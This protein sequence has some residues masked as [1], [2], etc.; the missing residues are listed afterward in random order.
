[1]ATQSKGSKSSSARPKA[2]A[3]AKRATKAPASERRQVRA[4]A[5]TA[6]DLPVGVVLG[7]ADR[8]AELV[9]REARRLWA[10]RP[11]TAT[12]REPAGS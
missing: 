10:Q 3:E 4:V 9:E 1:M 6:V 8:V 7:V 2:K 12:G 5:E 11:R